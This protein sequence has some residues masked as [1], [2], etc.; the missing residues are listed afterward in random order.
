MVIISQQY[1]SDK[2]GQPIGYDPDEQ[3]FASAETQID[4]V[5]M[6]E[7]VGGNPYD[8]LEDLDFFPP[9]IACA[10]I[11]AYFKGHWQKNIELFK[12]LEAQ[13]LQSFARKQR[14]HL[15]SDYV[16]SP[17]YQRQINYKD[18][19]ADEADMNMLEKQ[20]NRNQARDTAD[21]FNLYNQAQFGFSIPKYHEAYLDY[22]KQQTD[23]SYIPMLFELGPDPLHDPYQALYL[24]PEEERNQGR[25]AQN[26][27]LYDQAEIQV[28]IEQGKLA[29]SDFDPTSYEPTQDQVIRDLDYINGVVNGEIKV[30]DLFDSLENAQHGEPYS[31]YIAIGAMK[32][33][34][35]EALLTNIF[36]Q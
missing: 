24:A 13:A 32:I 2:T 25:A 5:Q 9:Y 16:E 3:L 29:A 33:Q 18:L 28:E 26:F 11:N 20:Q 21:Q 19:L 15:A 10:N 4:P 27:L 30:Y 23:Y 22:L 36:V 14:R 34:S 8:L 7:Y 12:D 6:Y 1:I 31:Q 17:M 35:F